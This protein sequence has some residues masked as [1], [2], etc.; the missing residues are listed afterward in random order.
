M[1]IS[2]VALVY[3][4]LFE[5]AAGRG[6]KV[7]SEKLDVTRFSQ[8]ISFH[9]SIEVAGERP[10][11]HPDG[12][13]DVRGAAKSLFILTAPTSEAG[14]KTRD[15]RMVLPKEVKEVTEILVINRDPPTKN[16]LKAAVNYA[17]ENPLVRLSLYDYRMFLIDVRSHALVSPCKICPL[18]EFELMRTDYFIDAV[19]LPR[20]SRDDPQAVWLGVRTG[21]VVIEDRLVETSGVMTVF[22]IVA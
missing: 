21:M 18:D 16:A 1:D 12:A 4:N 8:W 13:P 6:V 2:E 22:M 11:T 15:L 5:L 19:E 9:N 7:S 20:I 17:A 3:H 10:A 14:K